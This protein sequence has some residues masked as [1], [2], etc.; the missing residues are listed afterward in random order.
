[1]NAI[2][3]K[4]LIL[5]NCLLFL[6]AVA[7]SFLRADPPDPSDPFDPINKAPVLNLA[8]QK[9]LEVIHFDAAVA[10][11]KVQRGGVVRVTISGKPDEGYHTYPWTQQT[12]AQ[13]PPSVQIS[14]NGVPGIKPLWPGI[15]SRPEVVRRIDGVIGLEHA[16]PFT[17]SQDLLV[18]PETKPGVY[19]LTVL[20]ENVEVC[21]KSSC[22]TPASYRP[23][24]VSLEVLDAAVAPTKETLARLQGPPPPIVITPTAE[25]LAKIGGPGGETGK[26]VPGQ[27]NGVDVHNLWSFLW[28]AA[29]SAFLMLLTPCVFPMIPITVNFFIKQS[30]KEHH[31]P[32]AMASVYSGTI[33]VLESLTTIMLAP[34]FGHHQGRQQRIFQPRSWPGPGLFCPE[35]VRYVRDRVAEISWHAS[36]SSREGKGGTAGA[37]FMAMT[38]TITSF[39]C[40]GPFLGLMLGSV[41]GVQPPMINLVLGAVV[42]STTFAAPFFVLALFPS[43]L[44][45]LPRS[46]SWL[47][48]VKVT[49]G[50]LELGAALKFLSNADLAFF[51]GNPQVFNY[52]TVLAAWIALSVSCSVYLL[53]LIRLPHD[54]KAESIGVLRMMIA[55]GF[56]GLAIYL[57]PAMFGLQPAGIVGDNVIAFLPIRTGHEGES[58]IGSGE[59][60]GKAGKSDAHEGWYKDYEDAWKDAV[61]NNKLIFIDFTGQQCTN[62]RYNEG[63]VFT[64]PQVKAEMNKFVKVALYTDSVPSTKLTASESKA[65]GSRNMEWQAALTKTI[66]AKSDLTLPY[67]VIRALPTRIRRWKTVFLK[68]PFLAGPTARSVHASNSMCRLSSPYCKKPRRTRRRNCGR[69]MENDGRRPA[70]RGR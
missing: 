62:C 25:E 19:E 42:Y 8:T 32:L 10:P 47:N 16:S 5:A 63:S 39:T 34:R 29:I 14:F 11:Q 46:G 43:V 60:P 51:P 6:L 58:G 36:P 15:E 21:N 1:M 48:S 35:F 17:W 30:E 3:S 61:Q 22:L 33:I 56:L 44:K 45:K 49:M 59:G 69:L 2:S 55:V 9:L 68:D 24:S 13:A 20:L 52:D 31:N 57:A 18:D 27:N 26:S 66:L 12:K 53:G 65:Q 67:Y 40:T 50:F 37:V 23:L 64:L 28:F 70:P 54:D 41:A 7:P 38:F 4:R